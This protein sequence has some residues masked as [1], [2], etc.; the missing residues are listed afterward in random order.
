MRKTLL[1]LLTLL[2]LSLSAAVGDHFYYNDCYYEIL[3]ETELTVANLGARS[4]SSRLLYPTVEHNNK[5]YTVTELRKDSFSSN[6]T[7]KSFDFTNFP[8]SSYKI[9]KIG[10]D[11]F[12]GSSINPNTLPP[13]VEELGA[14]NFYGRSDITEV[15]FPSQLRVLGSSCFQ[16]CSNLVSVKGSYNLKEIGGSAFSFCQKLK[17]VE[18]SYNL[19][20]IGS[21]A[22][23][24]CNALESI[25]MPSVKVINSGAFQDC[26]KLT[27]IYLPS[28]L[29]SIG[30]SAFLYCTGLK[31]VIIPENVTSI[32][33]RAFEHCDKF[34]YVIF[35]PASEPVYVNWQGETADF[36]ACFDANIETK[37]YVP[38]R[39]TYEHGIE[40]I[41]FEE[42]E[43][44]YT[45]L[46]PE[47]PWV[48]NTPWPV[49]M[50]TA[51]L[52]VSAGEHSITL[53]ATFQE[54]NIK[55]TIPYTFSIAKAPLKVT[56]NNSEKEYGSFEQNY[57]CIFEGFVNG[58]NESCVRLNLSYLTEVAYDTPVGI[59]PVSAKVTPDNYEAT[60]IPGTCTIKKA[61]LTVKVSDITK[62]YGDPT[63]AFSCCYQGLKS[64]DTTISLT[65]PIIY[66][67]DAT[68][69]SN[70]GTYNISA[71]GGETA[72]YYF[73]EYIPALLTVNKAELTVI[74]NNCSRLYGDEN[75]DF[76]ASF[77]GFKLDDSEVEFSEP[78]LFSTTANIYSSVGSYKISVSGGATQNYSLSYRNGSL[79]INKAPLNI[80]VND[81][82]REYGE[83]NPKWSFT[84]EGLKNDETTPEV[85][86]NSDIIVNCSANTTSSVGEYDITPSGGEFYNYEPIEYISGK[87]TITK[88]PLTLKAKDATRPYGEYNPEFEL[89]YIGVK[90][91]D[92]TVSG[93][94]IEFTSPFTVSC[95]ASSKSSCGEY[96]IT[97][98]GGDARNYKI[99]DRQ[100]G[101][102]YI[103]KRTLQVWPIDAERYY[104]QPNP[105]FGLE[106]DGFVNGD[107]AE[108]LTKLPTVETIADYNTLPGTYELTLSGG[109]SHNYVFKFWTGKLRIKKNVLEFSEPDYTY[110][111]DGEEHWPDFVC[112]GEVSQSKFKEI[113]EITRYTYIPEHN[114]YTYIPVN[115]I[116]DAGE[117]QIKVEYSDDI[118]NAVSY[119]NVT[120]N[121]AESELTITNA[122]QLANMTEDGISYIEWEST[123]P[124]TDL[125]LQYSPNSPAVE[126][127]KETTSV[128]GSDV[129]R[130]KL[131][132]LSESEGDVI[133]YASGSPNHNGAYAT[134]HV[135][136]SQDAGI[137]NISID[138]ISITTEH[139]IANI[140]GKAPTEIV[141][142]YNMN[143]S[144]IYSGI[145]ERIE[146]VQSGIYII[147][148]SGKT[149]K[150]ML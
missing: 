91:V 20:E 138:D 5:T 103:T 2:P 19:E 21:D 92:N 110:D 27:S 31:S 98:S 17:T 34:E 105:E 23:L 122:E 42:K 97:V 93:A 136:I 149:Y 135:K 24:S 14:N 111:Y 58:E 146:V 113:L 114:V 76:S 60:I 118:L 71:S 25:N 104:G 82:T 129:T 74:P 94:N 53:T 44:V 126:L 49:S 117:Y 127:I 142:L 52:P 72:N 4:T 50:N 33:R 85:L 106:F 39:K 87:L 43:L 134:I 10:D 64:W 54:P 35:K 28:N 132:A 73:A 88:A 11:V 1:L 121:R 46:S 141:Y 32:G 30:E 109:E 89:D 55:L 133:L 79:T 12:K 41:S 131:H 102:L 119:A 48:N 130:Y 37:M 7:F 9:K 22:F 145:D 62:I 63:P 140:K 120:V 83:L 38:S 13:S 84:Y 65:S 40:M 78:L 47:I 125:S 123:A 6:L 56:V 15:I 29:V 128:E 75:P 115:S 26:P 137:G 99:T 147:I 86:G 101:I 57:S 16:R 100:S 144:L 51:N 124:H 112:T 69:Y 59:Y 139:L 36:A 81:A 61:P 3:S 95:Q 143:G 150:V 67:T 108:A 116:V 77:E 70:V 107:T 90:D 148:V 80:H 68:Q 18:L 45:G 66:V 8:P 96:S